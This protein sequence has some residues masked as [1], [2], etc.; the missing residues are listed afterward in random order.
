MD[1]ELKKKLQRLKTQ[2]RAALD[3]EDFAKAAEVKRAMEE[4]LITYSI[5][6][7]YL[8]YFVGSLTIIVEWAPKPYSNY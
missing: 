1:S 2:E 3:A 5:G 4:L 7:N 6:N 8:H